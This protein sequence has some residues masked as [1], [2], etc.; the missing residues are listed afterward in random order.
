MGTTRE[1]TGLSEFRN[2][3]CFVIKDKLVFY[4]TLILA[5][6]FGFALGGHIGTETIVNNTL[7]LCNEKPLECKFKYDILMYEQT[8]KVPY[9]ATKPVE[10]K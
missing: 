4:P 1:S 5:A 9:T 2:R 8:G 7:K 10:K 3:T 6:L